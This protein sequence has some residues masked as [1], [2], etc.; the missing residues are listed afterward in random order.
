MSRSATTV[1][2][3]ALALT[4]IL[5]SAALACGGTA[6]AAPGRG[7][8]S[9]E[10]QGARSRSAM[11]VDVLD[12]LIAS[13]RAAQRQHDWRSIRRFQ[14]ELTE[15]VGVSAVSEAR[16]SYQRAIADLAAATARSDARARAEFR[17]QLRVMCG[18][19]GLA[20]AF[21]ACGGDVIVW[22]D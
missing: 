15:Q 18:P 5:A 14:V 11:P 10:A 12:G 3:R 6:N 4:V 20:G 16:A 17:A 19:G 1:H 2:G 22:G 9:T 7:S 8:P 21:E 13:A